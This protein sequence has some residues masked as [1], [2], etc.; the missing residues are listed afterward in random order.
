MELRNQNDIRYKIDYSK[1]VFVYKNLHRDCWSIKQGGL[2]K[3]HTDKLRMWDCAFQVN[4]TGRKKVL[5]EKRKNVHAGI[6]GYIDT[7]KEDIFGCIFNDLFM[8]PIT[9][10]PYK[11]ETFVYKGSEEPIYSSDSAKLSQNKVVAI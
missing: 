3:A 10:N 7:Q 11:Y 2:V 9:Y 6:N 1:N 4:A 8:K 5:E